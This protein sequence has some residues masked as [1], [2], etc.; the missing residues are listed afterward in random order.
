MMHK[1]VVFLA[2][3]FEEIEAIAP[4]DILRR[5]GVSVTICG[6]GVDETRVAVGTH[7][8]KIQCDAIL[9]ELDP[10][11]YTL[12]YLPGGMPGSTNLAG[13]RQLLDF[14]RSVAA[15]GGWNC[16]ICAAPLALDAAGLLENAE[17]TCYPGIQEHIRTGNFTGKFIQRSGKILTACGPGASVDFALEI[18]RAMDM[19]AIAGQLAKAMQMKR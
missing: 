12:T 13:D 19:S 6:V 4:I 7:G 9:R 5:A 3:G 10:Q 17:Y 18:L 11:E 8:V 2:S 1:A 14:L 16:A 15:A